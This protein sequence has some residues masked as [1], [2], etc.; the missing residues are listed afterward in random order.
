M[1]QYVQPLPDPLSAYLDQKE[2][3]RKAGLQDLQGAVVAQGLLSK[4]QSQQKQA[5]YEKEIATANPSEEQE[6][7]EG[8]AR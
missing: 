6:K 3:N 7:I 4:M 5:S 1:A 2:T 8:R